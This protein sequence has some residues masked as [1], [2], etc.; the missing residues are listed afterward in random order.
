MKQLS[1]LIVPSLEGSREAGFAARTL[2]EIA[3][4]PDAAKLMDTEIRRRISGETGF[5]PFERVTQFR[6]LTK[7][8]EAGDELTRTF[9]MRR[10]VI[11]EKYAG[12]IA[13]MYP[14]AQAPGRRA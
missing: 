7:P 9:K 12:L 6:F 10:H 5:K 1:A 2:A 4:N 11:A 14:E 3:G 8:F 13:E